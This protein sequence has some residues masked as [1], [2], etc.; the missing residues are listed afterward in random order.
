MLENRLRELDAK[1]AQA[2][3]KT[4]RDTVIKDQGDGI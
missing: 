1:E 4:L 3:E 2:L